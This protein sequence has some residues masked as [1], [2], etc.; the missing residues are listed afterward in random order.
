[1]G[2]LVARP[3]LDWVA[4][5]VVAR[6]YLPLSRAW[7][8]ALAAEGSEARF[9]AD[10]PAINP[11]SQRLP[12]KLAEV[13]RRWNDYETALGVWDDLFFETRGSVPEDRLVA[14]ETAR[15]DAAHRLMAS[16]SLFLPLSRRLPAVRWEIAGPDQVAGEQSA[17]LKAGACP[18][19]V[20]DSVPV[21][22]SRGIPGV[23][24]RDHWLYFDSPV[25]SDRVRARV[26][27]PEAGRDAP[28]VILL[29][30][31]AMEN[32]QWRPGPEPLDHLALAHC[33]LVRPEGPWHGR[34]RLG[35]WYG[36]EPAIGRGVLGLLELFK[37]WIAEVGV[38]IAWAKETGRGPVAVAGVSLGAL[39]GQLLATAA[40]DWPAA[41]RPDA[42]FLVATSGDL[43][44]VAHNGSLGRALSLAPRLAEA[45]WDRAA[46][47]QWLPLLQPSGPPAVDPERIL[48]LVGAKDDLTP[49]AGGFALA[50]D[51][52]LAESNLLVRPQGHFSVWFGLLGDPRPLVRFSEILQRS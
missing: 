21:E 1:M 20:P 32:D 38:L 50:R 19:P 29:H 36:G 46:Q 7:A 18:F 2:R 28:T 44:S 10:L 17:R 15:R 12:H 25:L 41:L 4:V 22:V 43:L 51:W 52:G 6:S 47:A 40:Q 9:G 30:G 24:G 49:A 37:A 14:A 27:E 35:G 34:R 3:W 45:G 33:R 23:R 26:S 31:I 16:R 42:L 48:L 13:Q 11:S 39:T 5:N 8:A